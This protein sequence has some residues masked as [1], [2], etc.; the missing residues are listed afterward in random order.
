[1]ETGCFDHTSYQ[2]NEFSFFPVQTYWIGRQIVADCFVYVV[3]SRSFRPVQDFVG[4]T[5]IFG[6]D[7]G[8]FVAKK[9]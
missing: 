2:Q 5:L 3:K 9:E 1:M 6:R 8:F 4:E 7:Q